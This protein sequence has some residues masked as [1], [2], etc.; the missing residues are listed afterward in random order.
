MAA[1]S[2]A[3][4][5]ENVILTAGNEEAFFESRETTFKAVLL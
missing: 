2:N 4:N 3:V 5:K 1:D